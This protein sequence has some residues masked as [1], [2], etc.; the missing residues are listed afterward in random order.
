MHGD[1]VTLLGPQRPGVDRQRDAESEDTEEENSNA[2]AP[3]KLQH[4]T[5]I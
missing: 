3:G 5:L 1:G 2:P 4:S